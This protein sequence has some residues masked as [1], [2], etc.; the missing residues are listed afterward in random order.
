MTVIRRGGNVGREKG[1][2]NKQEKKQERG[3]RVLNA[4]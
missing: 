3:M 1:G 2:K 4:Q